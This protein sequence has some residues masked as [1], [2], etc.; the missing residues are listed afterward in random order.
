MTPAQPAVEVR[1][2]R[3]ETP[4]GDPIVDGVSFRLEAG[5]ALGLVGESGSGKT[6]AVLSLL[7]YT[8]AGARITEGEILIDGEVVDATIG[9]RRA[10]C[11]VATSP[12][13]PRIQVAR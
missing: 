3:V 7:G 6:T 13:C 4:S 9:R 1:G 11:E 12:T 10:D 2:L 5:E 8:Q